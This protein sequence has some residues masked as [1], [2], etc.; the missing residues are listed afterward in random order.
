[1]KRILNLLIVFFIAI[2]TTISLS[3]GVTGIGNNI[4]SVGGMTDDKYFEVGSEGDVDCSTIT[5]SGNFALEDTFTVLGDVYMGAAATRSTHTAA[6]A[7]DIHSTIEGAG[8]NSSTTLDVGTDLTVVG[9]TYMGAATTRSTHS[10]TGNWDVDGTLQTGGD[11][12]VLGNE[13]IFGN[14]EI[15]SNATADTIDIKDDGGGNVLKILTNNGQVTIGVD[16]T[17]STF[18]STGNLDVYGSIE[19]A[20]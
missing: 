3:Y 1:M 20:E 4:F 10:A 15:F 5:S 11:I 18:T 12:T 9:A 13:V 14:G 17:K 6:G 8:I 19:G 7:L 16:A 2:S